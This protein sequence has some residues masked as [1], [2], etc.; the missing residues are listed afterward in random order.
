MWW[1]LPTHCMHPTVPLSLHLRAVWPAV[2]H[3]LLL[4]FLQV[5]RAGE[6]L[7]EL[8]C[9][10]D[11]GRRLFHRA[12]V[13]GEPM[14]GVHAEDLLRAHHQQRVAVAAPHTLTPDT[15]IMALAADVE[16]VTGALALASRVAN[17]AVLAIP[18]RQRVVQRHGAL[19]RALSRGLIID[20]GQGGS[21]QKA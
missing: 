14:E 10:L 6:T 19:L 5:H 18:Q 4:D 15:S 11:V 13:L 3:E 2:A 16:L 20:Q 1:L 17:T 7:G 12:T 9:I 21:Q 8:H